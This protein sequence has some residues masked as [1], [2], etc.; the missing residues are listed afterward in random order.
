MRAI[1]A[2]LQPHVVSRVMDVLQAPPRFPGVNVGDGRGQRT[3][4][5]RDGRL[6]TDEEA[7]LISKECRLETPSAKALRDGMVPV[8]RRAARTGSPRA[9]AIMGGD[10]PRLVRAAA[11]HEQDGAL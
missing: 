10:F 8:I 6:V 7:S 9:G 11:G 2:V 3:N 5:A 4:R 1:D